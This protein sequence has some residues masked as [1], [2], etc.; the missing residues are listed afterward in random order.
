MKQLKIE[1]LMQ[2]RWEKDHPEGLKKLMAWLKQV[3]F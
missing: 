3:S 2:S 1:G